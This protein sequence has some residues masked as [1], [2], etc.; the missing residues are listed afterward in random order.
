MEELD[1]RHLQNRL[2]QGNIAFHSSAMDPLKDDAQV[3]LSFLNDCTLDAE[4][5]L[6]SS[7][8][9]Q[10]TQRMDSAYWWAN[11]RQTVL[12]AS[13]LETVKRDFQPDVVLE[14]A[15]HS[16]LQSTIAQCLEDCTP[17]PICIP[18]LIKDSDVCL[19]VKRALGA[20]FRAGVDLDFAAQYPGL[21]PSSTCFPAIRETISR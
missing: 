7:V 14:L 16:A 13:A 20:L 6:V 21:S 8:T 2:L 4:V 9:G 3:V 5:P 18:T 15:P 19:S 10:Q 17:V 11:I 12:F 1:R